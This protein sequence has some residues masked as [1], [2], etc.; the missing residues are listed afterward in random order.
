MEN[1]A[2]YCRVST[3]EQNIN[4]D[5]LRMQQE[6]LIKYAKKH[7]MN[8]YDTYI[9]G[10]YS[11]TSLNR[12]ELQRL[13]QDVRDKKINRILFIK[14]DRWSRGVKNYYKLQ[15]VLILISNHNI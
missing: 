8:I 4:G 6:N 14:I 2:L 9:D 5:S 12:P 11:A 3:Q 15:E 13:L 7:N 10:G 1:V